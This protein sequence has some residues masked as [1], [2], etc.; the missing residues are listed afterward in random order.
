VLGAVQGEVGQFVGV[1]QRGAAC[2]IDLGQSDRQRD[3]A[4]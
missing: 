3:F 2:R 1:G 4:L